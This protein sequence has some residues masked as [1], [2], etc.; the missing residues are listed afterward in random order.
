MSEKETVS[1]IKPDEIGVEAD[2]LL[3]LSGDLVFGTGKIRETGR[4]VRLGKRNASVLFWT[5]RIKDISVVKHNH[6]V[7]LPHGVDGPEAV[8]AATGA[9]VMQ[10]FQQNVKQTGDSFDVL[11]DDIIASFLEQLILLS[12]SSFKNDNA[13]NVD[14]VFVTDG[15][16]LEQALDQVRYNGRLV[17]VN[18]ELSALNMKSACEKEVSVQFTKIPSNDMVLNL[19]DQSII[20]PHGYTRWSFQ[21]CLTSFLDFMEKGN[22]VIPD[23]LYR[24]ISQ[25][26]FQKSKNLNQNDRLKTV[27]QLKP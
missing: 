18:N 23:S 7:L 5:Q 25:Q 14:C 6:F 16:K 13:K 10:I 11:G 20:F 4:Q 12:G 1:Q 17:V 2:C 21:R 24:V 3:T 15:S 22:L 8:V 27:I 9:A 19:F 26:A